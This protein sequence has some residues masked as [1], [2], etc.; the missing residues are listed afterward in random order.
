LNENEK[1][2][3]ALERDDQQSNPS[4]RVAAE[5]YKGKTEQRL[6]AVASDQPP[7]VRCVVKGN[8]LIVAQCPVCGKKHQH[9]AGGQA[10]PNYGHRLAHCVLRKRDP[11]REAARRRGYILVA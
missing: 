10:G 2:T 6:L 7:V 8:D 1:L 3:V 9:G 5:T 4:L 11:E